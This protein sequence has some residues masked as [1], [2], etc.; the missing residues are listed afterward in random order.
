MIICILFIVIGAVV[1]AFALVAFRHATTFVKKG[2][3]VE[4]AVIK[5]VETKD[6]DG[7]YYY[8]LFEITISEKETITYRGMNGA[9]YKSWKIGQKAAFIYVP[10]E[11]P[12]I[13]RLRYWSIFG[14][15][16]VLL[17]IAADFIVVGFGYFLLKAYF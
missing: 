15:P 17:A 16:L 9:T 4:G 13:R 12:H 5:F 11:V 8:P 2:R 1:L 14:F 3:C 7:V 10:G 6:E